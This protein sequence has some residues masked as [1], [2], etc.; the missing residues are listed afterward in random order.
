MKQKLNKYC[1][2]IFS[3]VIA[4]VVIVMFYLDLFYLASIILI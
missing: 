4:I 3:V 1:S 2:I